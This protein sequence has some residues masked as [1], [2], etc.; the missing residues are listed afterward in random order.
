MQPVPSL[1]RPEP[2]PAD[3]L[4]L[5][6]IGVVAYVLA[7]MLHEGAGHGGACLISGGTPLVVSTVHMECSVGTRL[8]SAGGTIAN[9]AAAALFF[10]IARVARR[11]QRIHFFC[12]LSMTVNLLMATGYF[13]FSGVGGFGDWAVFIEGL[14]PEWLLR[15]AL[16]VVG[17]LS[18]LVAVRFSLLE[19][20]PLIGSGKEE[21]ITRATRLMRPPYFAGG[22]LACIAGAFNPAG[23]YLIALSAAASTFGGTSALVWSD[24]WLRDTRRIPLGSE[25]EPYPITRSW[26]WIVLAIAIAIAFVG[27]IGPGVRLHAVARP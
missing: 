1:T 5:S 18:Y 10:V 2:V 21:R 14:G 24:N 15:L 12:W 13:L 22:V 17:A 8:V 7:T 9:F 23:W 25:P 16:V 19:L 4:T 27:L 20:R 11:S 3:A 26:F 6:A